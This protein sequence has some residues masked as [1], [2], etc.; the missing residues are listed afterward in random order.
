MKIFRLSDPQHG[1]IDITFGQEPDSYTLTASHVPNDCLRDLAAA[2]SR[3]LAGAVDEVI[4]FSLEPKFATC[5]LHRDADSVR[6][7]VNHPEQNAPVFDAT[8]PLVAFARRLRFELLRMESRY[9][10]QSGWTTEP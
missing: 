4:E 6:V 7:H 10:D 8:F 2:T 9:S 1:W 3:L 5:Q